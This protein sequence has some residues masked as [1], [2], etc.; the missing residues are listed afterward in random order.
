MAWQTYLVFVKP[1]VTLIFWSLCEVGGKGKR[2]EEF[3]SNLG[4][5]E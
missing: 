1:L 4:F 2:A 3:Y 5:A